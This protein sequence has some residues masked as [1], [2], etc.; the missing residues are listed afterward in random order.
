MNYEFNSQPGGD[1]VQDDKQI[2]TGHRQRMRAKFKQ[3]GLDGFEVHESLELLLY[4]AVPRKDTNPIAHR[5]LDSF[6]SLSAVF[7]APVDALKECGLSENAALLLKLVPQM[8]RLYLDDKFDSSKAVDVEN[9][10]ARLLNKFVGRDYE[11]VVLTLLDA[12]RKEVFCGVIS[13][14]SVNS[15]DLYIRKIIENAMI[16]NASFAI[17]AHNHPSGFALPSMADIETTK[18]VFSALSL[19]GVRLL[20]HIVVADD[21]YVSMRQS[22]LCTD[23]L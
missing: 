23:V 13:K 12:K 5:L 21:D 2:H 16:Y 11:A 8:S 19:V 17:L 3:S 7:D 18:T 9:I 6:G 15:C 14:G 20:D 1:G 4:Y 22:G 10:G